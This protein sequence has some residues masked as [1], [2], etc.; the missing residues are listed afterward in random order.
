MTDSSQS[1]KGTR[2]LLIEDEALVAMLVEDML[3]DQ[4]CSVVATGARLEEALLH[5][6]D[7][8]LQFDVALVDLNLAG[9][10]T[11][12]VASALAERNIPFA[13]STG[14]GVNGLPPEWRDRPTLQKPF[15]SEDMA[16]VLG[17][18]LGHG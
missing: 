1:L 8:N 12:A 11:F 4:G 6:K 13:F 18:A 3:A 7:V 10:S 16:R 17:K 2:V 5:A 15:T 9:E 14:Y